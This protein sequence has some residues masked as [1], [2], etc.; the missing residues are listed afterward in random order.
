MT[1]RRRQ[2]ARDMLASADYAAEWDLRGL[3]AEALDSIDAALKV[4]EGQPHTADGAGKD[5]CTACAMRRKLTR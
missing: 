1:D 3:L 5:R 4:A 2:A